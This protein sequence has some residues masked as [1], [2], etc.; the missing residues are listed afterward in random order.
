MA[1]QRYARGRVA[2]SKA[3]S[4]TVQKRGFFS[5][6]Q[7]A[8]EMMGSPTHVN[9]LFDPDDRVIALE[10]TDDVPGSYP[11]R[12]PSSAARGTRVVSA[13]SF[14]RNFGIDV[15]QSRRYVPEFR[16][17]LLCVDLTSEGVLI[18]GDPSGEEADGSTQ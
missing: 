14:A 3:P 18:G 17:G 7:A 13:S 1:F 16:D 5:F 11:V 6:N 15:S 8:L 12:T 9:L 10:P 2:K 4:F